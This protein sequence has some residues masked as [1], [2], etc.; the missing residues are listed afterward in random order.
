MSLNRFYTLFTALLFA[1]VLQAQP[2]WQKGVRMAHAGGMAMLSGTA[3]QMTNAYVNLEVG[4]SALLTD[5]S[6]L[7]FETALSRTPMTAAV[8][9]K[10][11]VGHVVYG[12]SDLKTSVLLEG[13]GG[14][15]STQNWTVT[16]TTF[17][18]NYSRAGV[19]AQCTHWFSSSVGV[20]VWPQL[21]R[22]NA[23]PSGLWEW[24][25]KLPVGVQWAWYNKR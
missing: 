11:Y 22:T 19:G 4:T 25:L 2:Y 13:H 3:H 10:W 14:L 18:N 8:E 23:G 9:M 21:D 5:R 15:Q 1:V 12:R 6:A 17:G 7:G 20:Y 24:Q 16:G